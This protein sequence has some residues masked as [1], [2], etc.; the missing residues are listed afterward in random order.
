MCQIPQLPD[1]PT[2]EELKAEQLKDGSIGH[3]MCDAREFLAAARTTGQKALDSDGRLAG[4]S[5]P[6]T[7][8]CDVGSTLSKNLAHYLVDK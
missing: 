3:R 1:A 8:S 6:P 5:I 4:V 7:I 2:E